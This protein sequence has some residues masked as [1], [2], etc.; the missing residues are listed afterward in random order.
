M[1]IDDLGD[2]LSAAF[3]RHGAEIAL[4]IGREAYTY[5]DLW[6][7]AQAFADAQRDVL[8]A[9]GAVGILPQR[10]LEAYVGVLGAVIARR[11]YVSL[12]M[13]F[14]LARQLHIA[15]ESRCRVIVADGETAPRRLELMAGLEASSRSGASEPPARAAQGGQSP[16]YY[17]FTSGTTGRP[18]GVEVMRD[19]LAAYLRTIDD[20]VKLPI[21]ARCSQFFELSF[22]V[23]VHDMFYTWFAGGV[24]C[25]MGPEDGANMVAFAKARRIDCWYS[26]PSAIALADRNGWLAP[27]ALPDLRY[28]LFAGEALSVGLAKQWLAACPKAMGFNLYGP[29]EGTITITARA[30]GADDLETWTH[31]S[32]PIGVANPG[33]EVVLV[34]EHGKVE[35]NPERGELWIG[36]PQVVAGYVNNPEETQRRFVEHSFPGFASRRWYRTGDLVER[37]ADGDLVFLSRIDD[38][39]KVRGY[40]IELLEVEEAVRAAAGT[41]EVAVAPWPT[42]E[43]GGADGLVAFVVG[44]S[45]SDERIVA[46]CEE[47]LPVYMA[48][49]RIVRVEQLLLNQNGKVD[50]KALVAAHLSG[51]A[52]RQPIAAGAKDIEANLVSAWSRLFPGRDV[53]PS[54]TFAALE[55]DSLSYINTL[56]ESERHLGSLPADWTRRSIADLARSVAPQETV[57]WRRVD[58]PALVRAI[59]IILVLMGHFGLT[60]VDTGA[61]GAMMLLSGFFFGASHL[62]GEADKKNVL[63]FLL[64]AMQLLGAYYLVFFPVAMLCGIPLDTQ[65]LFLMSDLA[66]GSLGYL[67]YVHALVHIL[68]AAT[69]LG[70]IAQSKLA[71]WLA[72]RE[73][74]RPLDPE[75]LIAGTF[76]VAGAFVTFVTPHFVRDLHHAKHDLAG[77]WWRYTFLGQMFVF[78]CGAMLASTRGRWR[79]WTALALLAVG[80]GLSW[81][82]GFAA[83]GGLALAA[84]L[85]LVF[86]TD[87]RAPRWLLRPLYMLADATLFIYLLHIPI[88]SK[89]NELGFHRP[90]RMVAV[91]VV[92]L[93]A[94]WAWSRLM[95][96]QVVSELGRRLPGRSRALRPATSGA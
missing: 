43:A 83:E 93:A 23:S 16:V 46:A 85:A 18:K 29:T 21:G 19:N 79:V 3:Q 52:Q 32:V 36:G 86:V 54:T 95:R 90:A 77:G 57:R 47:V 22:D 48:P 73:Q 69:A 27:N 72:R 60:A 4:E 39:V 42:N 25:P 53:G 75:V 26:V 44:A 6:A 40:R 24:L 66:G 20:V 67:W 71:G 68:L 41:R 92:G 12:N 62:A 64:P 84:A 31:A 49:S 5:G 59:A 34:A 56:L 1:R 80:A 58:I 37:A 89:L 87:L 61:V 74:G 15:R 81:F 11:P 88:G 96:S 50:R 30:F 13:K 9:D 63:K 91:V 7:R 55:G 10:S 70:W 45:V 8:G 2:L 35:P 65:S 51:A 38:Q 76:I 78:G 14:P 28:C 33:G 17:M 94:N 82:G